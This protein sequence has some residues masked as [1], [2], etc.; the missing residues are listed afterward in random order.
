MIGNALFRPKSRILSTLV[1]VAASCIVAVSPTVAGKLEPVTTASATQPLAG[2]DTVSTGSVTTGIFASVA[3][4]FK[5]SSAVRWREIEQSANRLVSENC[6]GDATCHVRLGLLDDTTD[7]VRDLALMQR[8]AAINTAVNRLID[9]RSDKDIYG[10]LDYWATPVEILTKGKGDCEDFAILKMAA[11]RAA[12]VPAESMALVVLR[13][14]SRNFFH[15]VLAVSTNNGTYVLDNLHDAVLTD[16][17]LPQYQALY[18]LSAQ[19]AWVH[20]YKRGSEFALQ[21]RPSSLET[22]LPG[23]GVLAPPQSDFIRN[24]MAARSRV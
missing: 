6:S 19:G 12:G 7:A 16:R 11:L 20:G 15:A 14:A 17:Q 22:V 5:P 1:G 4:P 13:D 23:E 18:S 24:L 9:Y 8:V 21:K 2:L 10:K 3:F